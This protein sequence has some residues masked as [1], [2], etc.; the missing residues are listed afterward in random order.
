MDGTSD[1]VAA[2]MPLRRG[3]LELRAE[4][5]VWQATPDRVWRI[6]RALDSE[7]RTQNPRFSRHH[8]TL[9][10]TPDGWVLVNH[11]PAGM[12]VNGYRLDRLAVREPV[13]L[14]L[15]PVS[16]GMMIQLLHP[17]PQSG[18]AREPSA[19]HHIDRPAIRI[20]RAP[21]NDV[22]LAD[23]L[24]S[25]HHAELRRSG[26][27]WELVDLGSANGT[28]VNG[29]RIART[30]LHPT[31]LVVIGHQRLHLV[32]DRLE[33][34]VDTGDVSFAA[35][36]LTVATDTGRVLLD[37]VSFALPQRSFLAVVGPTGA[38]KSTLLA[39]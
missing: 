32:G 9:T 8:A 35:S 37:N 25:R 18:D 17:P 27:L 36:G 6:G 22:V 31:D 24:V 26:A 5:R 14:W 20:G 21:G 30:A 11:S 15:G 29:A 28:Y 4:G 7:V 19:V 23:L 1:P 39:R 13:T 12:F 16:G 38:G 2:G 10:P 3:P 33:E 34:Y